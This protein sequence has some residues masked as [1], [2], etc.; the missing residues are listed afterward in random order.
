MKCAQTQPA[1][2]VHDELTPDEADTPRTATFLPD[3]ASS[4]VPGRPIDY[5]NEELFHDE[6]GQA[7]DPE[8]V[9]VVESFEACTA[10]ENRFIV[11]WLGDVRGLRV[12]DLGCGAGEAATYFALCGA[13]VAATDI[14][15]GMLALTARVARRYGVQVECVRQNSDR[16]DF[17]DNTFDVVYA[18]NLLHHVHLDACLASVCRVLKPDGR[19]V[20]WDPLRHNPII[21]IYRR[22][23][24]AV[25][26]EDE[27]PLAIA[28]L[29]SF[30][31]YFQHVEHRCFWLAGLWIFMKFFLI[32]R[33]DPSKE[34]YWKK[35]IID[36]ER[37]EKTYKRLA[38]IDRFLLKWCPPLRRM[39]W[40]LTVC[41]RTPR[42]PT[43]ISGR[44]VDHQRNVLNVELPPWDDPSAPPERVPNLQ[45]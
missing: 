8:Q 32:E 6:W 7:L 42:K 24:A 2:D 22:M 15:A 45:R 14:S 40:N 9:P 13:K 35:I 27:T 4:L 29:K 21:N 33:V 37:L 30:R 25:R 44:R 16:L 12:L 17:P 28:D 36:A 1:A 19:F 23:A 5:Q 41:A 11:Q 34:R 18:A 20:S 31:D 38:A 3:S 26:T 39:C 43:P 10:P